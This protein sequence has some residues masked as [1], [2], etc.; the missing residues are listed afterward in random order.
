[1]R[2]NNKYIWSGLLI[3]FFLGSVILFSGKY[4]DQDANPASQT[5]SEQEQQQK[6]KRCKANETWNEKTKKCECKPGFVRSQLD[7]RCKTLAEIADELKKEGKKDPCKA[8]IK[9]LFEKFDGLKLKINEGYSRFTILAS[10]FFQQIHTRVSNPCRDGIVAYCFTNALQVAQELEYLTNDLN[11][12]SSQLIVA[13]GICDLEKDFS[14]SGF[15]SDVT[16]L[17]AKS[18]QVMSSKTAI[19]AKLNELACD[20]NELRQMGES[21]TAQKGLDPDFLQDGAVLSEVPG[22]GTDQDF[23]GLQDEGAVEM[24]GYNIAVTLYDAGPVKDDVFSLSV[25][26]QG[27]LGSTPRGALRSYGLNLPPGTYTA[28]VAV[29]STEQ[30]GGTFFIAAYYKGRRIADKSGNIPVG[31]SV[32]LNF[33]IE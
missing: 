14:I 1:M 32:S 23:D 13:I 30:G 11:D 2:D 33:T 15:L 8:D 19:T 27:N 7:N 24:S 28:T 31:A 5:I 3:L 21:I 26:G 12:L 20:E 17:K 29:I 10:K 22:D 9:V 16:N 6:P 25:T 4:H 18:S